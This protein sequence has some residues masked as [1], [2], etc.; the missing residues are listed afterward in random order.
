MSLLALSQID[1]ETISITFNWIMRLQS[2]TGHR[3]ARGC[4][5]VELR[6]CSQ[7]LTRFKKRPL[8]PSPISPIFRLETEQRKTLFTIYSGLYC[9]S[10]PLFWLANSDLQSQHILQNGHATQTLSFN[11]EVGRGVPLYG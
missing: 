5:E 8:G 3:T 6:I 10:N 11:S 2:F 7:K 9:M 4:V 1:I